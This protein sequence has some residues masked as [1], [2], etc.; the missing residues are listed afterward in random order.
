MTEPKEL[1]TS[2]EYVLER[3][4]NSESDYT[5]ILGTT[6][7]VTKEDLIDQNGAYTVVYSDLDKTD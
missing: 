3:K 7:T 6:K 1:W 5:E 4:A 2:T